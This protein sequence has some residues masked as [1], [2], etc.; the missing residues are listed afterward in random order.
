MLHQWIRQFFFSQ[1]CN[2]WQGSC[3]FYV[4]LRKQIYQWCILD[5]IQKRR[6]SLAFTAT[7]FIKSQLRTDYL[8]RISNICIKKCVK[9]RQK[10]ISFLNKI[11]TV[12]EL[13]LKKLTLARQIFWRTL[14][15]NFMKIQLS[16]LAVDNY[17][18]INL[19][20]V[21]FDFINVITL[22]KHWANRL[23]NTGTRSSRRYA[24]NIGSPKVRCL[25]T[26]S[27]S[28]FCVN[29]S[30]DTEVQNVL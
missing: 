21:H 7:I 17:N 11:L 25:H 15:P 3:L 28:L 13:I 20:C 16:L 27:A 2:N 9:Y 29:K 1:C 18:K 26:L 5:Y 30:M 8:Y 4:L 6:R 23:E 19:H 10:S 22:Q 24:T 14:L 12:T